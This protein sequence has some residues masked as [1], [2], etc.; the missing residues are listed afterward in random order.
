M[1]KKLYR[2][3]Y[4][5][6]LGGVCS[7]LG[8][9]FDI[10]V[11][12]VRLL[13]C[14]SFFVMGVGFIPYIV[15]WI[16]LPRKGYIYNNFNNPYVDYRVPPQQPADGPQGTPPPS[17][18]YGN[19]PFGN[20]PFNNP[21]DGPVQNPVPSRQSSHA[22][23]IVGAVLIVVGGIILFANYDLIP[24]I[25][26]ERLWPGIFVIVGLALLVS[27]QTGRSAQKKQFNNDNQ[28]DAAGGA[29]QGDDTA[30]EA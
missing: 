15:L 10:D 29:V 13:F 25:D 14:F 1:N 11:T 23:A 28:A 3:E 22:A 7:G 4:N 8:E 2:N 6:V 27:A 20:N 26:F 19:N 12:I 16:V 9:Y 18:S 17:S 5:R 30:H 21:Y 24:D